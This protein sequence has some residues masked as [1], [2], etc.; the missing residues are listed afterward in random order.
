VKVVTPNTPSAMAASLN[1]RLGLHVVAVGVARPSERLQCVEDREF[2]LDAERRQ[3]HQGAV[4]QLGMVVGNLADAGRSLRGIGR[5]PSIRVDVRVGVALDQG[6][7]VLQAIDAFVTVDVGETA[8][9]AGNA[10]RSN[11]A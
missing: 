8:A 6:R 2:R 11:T 10:R 1:A 9:P 5:Q 4:D 3:P 7:H